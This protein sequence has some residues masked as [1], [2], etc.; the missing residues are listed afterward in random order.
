MTKKSSYTAGPSR[1]I[2]DAM[3]L[4]SIQEMVHIEPRLGMV[5]TPYC[6]NESKPS[7]EEDDF[8][9]DKPINQIIRPLVPEFKDA[10]ESA[11]MMSFDYA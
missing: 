10:S 5:M 7:D 8:H 6:Y 3:N 4:T 1:T 11:Y 2:D 9:V